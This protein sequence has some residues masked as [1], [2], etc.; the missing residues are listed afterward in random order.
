MTSPIHI[1]ASTD[2]PARGEEMRHRRDERIGWAVAVPW[3]GKA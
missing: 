1:L 2:L 3:S